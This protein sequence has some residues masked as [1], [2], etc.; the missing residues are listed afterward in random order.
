[1]ETS[2]NSKIQGTRN[3]KYRSPENRDENFK[4]T[5]QRRSLN[6]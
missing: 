6:L 4:I 2:E 5:E 3:F 1:M